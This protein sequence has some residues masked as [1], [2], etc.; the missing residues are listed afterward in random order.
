MSDRK[1]SRF[2]T[3]S[4]EDTVNGKKKSDGHLSSRFLFSHC[5][6]GSRLRRWMNEI[7]SSFF[8]NGACAGGVVLYTV[9]GAVSIH[10]ERQTLFP[11]L[12]SVHFRFVRPNENLSSSNAIV[13]RETPSFNRWA[14]CDVLPY[15]ICTKVIEA[16]DPEKE[17]ITRLLLGLS[18]S[19][20]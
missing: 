11:S 20:L 18:D 7:R 10:T 14:K 15:T 5:S 4:E 13:S 8:F 3:D 9:V 17:K 1:S 16:G 19:I 2:I 12:F 6:G